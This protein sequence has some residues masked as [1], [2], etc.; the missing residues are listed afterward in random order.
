F[1]YDGF[2]RLVEAWTPA[3]QSCGSAPQAG[4][5][6][7]PAPYWTGYTYDNAGQRTS[8]TQHRTGGD[9]TTTYCYEGAQPHTL[10]GTSTKDDCEAPS[11]TY[12]YDASGNTTSRPGS[13]GAQILTWNAE[14]RLSGLT[15][16]AKATD[17]L[18]DAD[19]NLL[20]RTEK[21]GERVLYAGA[22]ELH[23]TSG[24]TFWAQRFYGSQD[25]T[26]AVR[27]NRTGANKLSYL[28]SDRHGSSNL[29]VAADT[30]AIVKRYLTVFGAER[31]GAVGTWVD[32]RGFL[33]KTQDKATGLTH[34]DAREYDAVLGRFMSV[35]PMLEPEKHQSLNGYGYAEN[36]PVTFSDP[37]G[38]AS[39]TCMPGVDC[40]IA[41]I[42]NEAFVS[43]ALWGASSTGTSGT[44]WTSSG[45]FTGNSGS[46]LVATPP[47]LLMGPD[48]LQLQFTGPTS[49]EMQKLQKMFMEAQARCSIPSGE[50]VN[51]QHGGDGKVKSGGPWSVAFRWLLGSS[52]LTGH[53]GGNV[54]AGDFGGNTVPDVSYDGDDELT[55][56][57]IASE[58]MKDTRQMVADQ[59]RMTGQKSGKDT[60]STTRHHDG[61]DRTLAQIAGVFGSDFGGL[62]IG[63]D[64]REAQGV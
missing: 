26:V 64:D 15:E 21:N 54:M 35:D 9:T 28:T 25:L 59:F 56:S 10:T 57:L 41:V 18:Y 51:S 44:S 2:R 13:T 6:S 60:Y 58:S 37:T 7:G 45:G 27:S 62:I 50:L 19:G 20:I 31:S 52:V 63:Q 29:A 17:Y 53:P 14:G 34:V 4:S 3:S 40:S 61:K 22:T 49:P 30:Q 32:D 48:P 46:P 55:Q 33:G 5:L 8:E 11:R 39:S 43:P 36:N 47:P 23:L 16:G 12:G 38:Q 1:A 42:I 24:N